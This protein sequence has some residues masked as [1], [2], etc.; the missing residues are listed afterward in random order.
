MVDVLGTDASDRAAAVVAQHLA[1]AAAVTVLAVALV[2]WRRV[3]A[4]RES[5]E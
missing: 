4:W 1:V 5:Q 2:A 3:D